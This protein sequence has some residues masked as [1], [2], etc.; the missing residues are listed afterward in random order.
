M[1]SFVFYW[2]LHI[3]ILKNLFNDPYAFVLFI[4][5]NIIT[6]V[7]CY[8]TCLT[9]LGMLRIEATHNINIGKMYILS[10]YSICFINDIYGVNTYDLPYACND[11]V[12]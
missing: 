9:S 5:M 2:F 10:K 1:T 8:I 11:K 6:L 3:F 12:A 7:H 4:S